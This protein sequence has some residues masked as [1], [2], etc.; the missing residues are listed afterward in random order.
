MR[1]LAWPATLEP[2][3]FLSPTSGTR[4]ASAWSS[5]S[6]ASRHFFVSGFQQPAE[7]YQRIHQ[8][9][10]LRG[11]GQEGNADIF[12]TQGITGTD[13]AA[14]SNISKLFSCRVKDNTAV[15]EDQFTAFTKVGVAEDDKAG[16]NSLVARTD[17]DNLET[18]LDNIS[19]STGR[20]SKRT[21]SASPMATKPAPKKVC[22]WS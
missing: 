19:R 9:R 4:A 5:P 7:P 14:R 18:C 17:T 1:T 3:A 2:G 13:G 6:K 15:T 20:T 16:A 11:I 22:P 10:I 12:D 8:C 21:P